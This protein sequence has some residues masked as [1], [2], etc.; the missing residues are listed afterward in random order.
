M[1]DALLL[2]AIIFGLMGVAVA[3]LI[4]ATIFTVVEFISRVFARRGGF[5]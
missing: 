2:L 3:I 4:C 5:D 1:I